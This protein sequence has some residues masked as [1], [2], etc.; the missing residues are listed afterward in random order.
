M[1]A[2]ALIPEGGNDIGCCPGHDWPRL[3]RY[4]GRYRSRHSHATDTACNKTAKRARRRT[5]R[6]KVREA[7][8]DRST[9]AERYLRPAG[10]CYGK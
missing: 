7:L 2:Y 8:S 5:D 6:L 1:R 10:E 3:R 4:A 9:D